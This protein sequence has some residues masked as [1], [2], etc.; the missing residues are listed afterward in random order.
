MVGRLADVRAGWFGFCLE[1]EG[2]VG[3]HLF[4]FWPPGPEEREK[5]ISP[6]ERGIVSAWRSESHLR[7]VLSSSSDAS[8]G[9]RL[10]A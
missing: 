10:A 2:W 9:P 5:V 7:A 8:G 4:T 3:A 1:V 6:M